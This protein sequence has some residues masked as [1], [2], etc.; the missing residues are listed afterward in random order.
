MARS[1]VAQPPDRL[2]RRG[3]PNVTEK[4]PDRRRVRALAVALKDADDWCCEACRT[5]AKPQSV[6]YRMAITAIKFLE[7]WGKPDTSR[8]SSH[9]E[10]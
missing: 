1:R 6:H 9:R 3:R 7:T 2:P 5:K 10:R 4:H 8:P